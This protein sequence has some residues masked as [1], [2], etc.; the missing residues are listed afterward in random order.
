MS[1]SYWCREKSLQ[2]VQALLVF[3]SSF[4]TKWAFHVACAARPSV[5][6]HLCKSL[7]LD[8]WLD[9]HQTC[10]WWPPAGEPASTMC[11]KSRSRSMVTWYGNFCDVTKSLLLAGKWLDRDQTHSFANLPFLSPFPF[12][13]HSNPQMAVS[14]TI[15]HIMKQF[16]KLVVI[17]YGLTF[18]LSMCTLYEAPLHSL[19]R[20]SNINLTSKVW[21]HQSQLTVLSVD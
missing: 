17:Q 16:V 2:L 10:T 12:L 5:C 9:C 14:S 13:S 19:S 18:C 21:L 8:E 11:W 20:L 7:L 1:L 3:F 6:K 4:L 15:A